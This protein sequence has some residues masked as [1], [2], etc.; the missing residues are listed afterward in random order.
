MT[1]D[2]EVRM[3]FEAMIGILDA[4]IKTLDKLR[5]LLQHLVAAEQ[6][7]QPARDESRPLDIPVVVWVKLSKVYEREGAQI[8]WASPHPSLNYLSPSTAWLRGR[9]SSVLQILDQLITGAVT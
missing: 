6:Q 2:P 9:G 5:A 1:V 7:D 3:V 4:Q 8:W